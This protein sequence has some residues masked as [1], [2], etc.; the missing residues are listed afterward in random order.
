LEEAKNEDKRKDRISL[1]N[2]VVR[3]D[4]TGSAEKDFETIF[5]L[6]K[7]LEEMSNGKV[8]SKGFIYSLLR[9]WRDTFADLDSL[10]KE[11]RIKARSE[12]KRYMPLLKYQLVRNVKDEAKREEIGMKIARCMAWIRIPVSWVSLRTR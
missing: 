8:I 5:S 11:K 7:T 12:R 10:P 6:A 1:F 2:E 4:S 9:M 3:W